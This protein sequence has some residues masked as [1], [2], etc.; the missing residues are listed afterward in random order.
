MSTGRR[1]PT[2]RDPAATLYWPTDAYSR[3]VL[4]ALYGA[5][6]AFVQTSAADIARVGTVVRSADPMPGSGVFATKPIASGQLV[7]VYYGALRKYSAIIETRKS[8]N[9]CY[10]FDIGIQASSVVACV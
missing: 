10:L 2:I 1:P 5:L 3:A 4:D 6:T 7:A 9:S 8:F